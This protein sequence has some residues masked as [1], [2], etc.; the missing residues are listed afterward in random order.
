[1][2]DEKVSTFTRIWLRKEGTT[3]VKP[4]LI[5]DLAKDHKNWRG[6]NPDSK[7]VVLPRSEYRKQVA[8]KEE[9]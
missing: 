8:P 3:E 7:W 5:T 4:L 6:F 9:S 2:S 1:M